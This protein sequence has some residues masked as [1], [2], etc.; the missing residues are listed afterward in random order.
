[1]R[2]RKGKE[3]GREGEGR[4]EGKRKREGGDARRGMG[5]EEKWR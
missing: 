3:G 1:M 2:E 4:G 5:G